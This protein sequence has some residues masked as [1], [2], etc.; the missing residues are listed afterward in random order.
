MSTATEIPSSPTKGPSL[1]AGAPGI[2]ADDDAP[3][4]L[5]PD[6]FVL[7]GSF[8]YLGLRAAWVLARRAGRSTAAGL[9]EGVPALGRGLWGL[10]VL[11][12]WC[13]TDDEHGHYKHMPSWCNKDDALV[14]MLKFCEVV[15]GLAVIAFPAAFLEPETLPQYILQTFLWA[16][17][18]W[19][20]CLPVVQVLFFALGPVSEDFHK[21]LRE[22]W[23]S[24][25]E[26]V[27][28]SKK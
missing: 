20:V 16:C 8:A 3:S 10:L 9:W 12:P 26:E 15:C 7:A 24:A 25:V 11:V 17:A 13:F 14:N 5:L 28:R 6:L 22:H 4:V 19:F 21:S 23:T 18:V 2:K 27:Q 1:D